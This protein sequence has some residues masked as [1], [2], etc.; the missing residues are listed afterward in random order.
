MQKSP[1]PSL[2]VLLLSLAALETGL[3]FALGWYWSGFK[4]SPLGYETCGL[5]FIVFPMFVYPAFVIGL[6]LR[7]LPFFRRRMPRYC[8]YLP[9]LLCAVCSC[10]FAK[11]L[12]MGMLCIASMIALPVT[13]LL[14]FIGAR[15]AEEPS[16]E[17]VFSDR[18]L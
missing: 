16:P 15:R 17:Q 10:A 14:G 6:L 9:L 4:W 8:L 12:E 11:S 3:F 1:R 13:D 2:A 7:L 5:E 18:A